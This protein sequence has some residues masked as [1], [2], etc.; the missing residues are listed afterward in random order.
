[1]KPITLHGQTFP[2]RRGRVGL[3]VEN[4]V[5]LPIAVGLTRRDLVIALDSYLDAQAARRAVNGVSQ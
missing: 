1:M 3:V 2:V 4:E 5:G